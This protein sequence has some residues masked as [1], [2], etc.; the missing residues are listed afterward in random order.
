MDAVTMTD[1]YSISS[2]AF[3]LIDCPKMPNM[4]YYGSMITTMLT[5]KE[6]ANGNPIIDPFIK[7][8]VSLNTFQLCANPSVDFHLFISIFQYTTGSSSSD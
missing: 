2:L 5:G 1:S 6:D 3:F 4:P 8:S 7:A